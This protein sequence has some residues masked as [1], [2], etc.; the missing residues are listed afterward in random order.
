MVDVCMKYWWIFKPVAHLKGWNHEICDWKKSELRQR[1]LKFV[2]GQLHLSKGQTTLPTTEFKPK[3]KWYHNDKRCPIPYE[4]QESCY[5]CEGNQMKFSVCLPKPPDLPVAWFLYLSMG[6]I[7]TQSSNPRQIQTIRRC[8]ISLSRT[9]RVF[10]KEK[11]SVLN[12]WWC[13][14]QWSDWRTYCD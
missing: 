10:W 14:G 9:P 2:P 6:I 5:N 7:S 13:H 8:P 3:W 12:S 1:Y 11:N 4:I